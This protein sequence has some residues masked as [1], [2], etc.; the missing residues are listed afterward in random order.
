MPDLKLVLNN[1]DLLRN[2]SFH[3]CVRLNRYNQSH[4][5]SF[6]P[7]DGDFNLCEFTVPSLTPFNI[8]IEIDSF[9][10]MKGTHGEVFIS[11]TANHVV[12]NCVVTFPLPTSV[13]SHQF[14]CSFGQVCVR[15]KTVTWNAGRVNFGKEAVLKGFL[16]LLSVSKERP[17]LSIQFKV[18]QFSASGLKIDSLHIDNVKYKAFKGMRSITQSGRYDIRP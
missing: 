5:L 11:V 15:E 14:S 12:E 8:P 4:E 3:P 16:S 6:I 10:K 1:S 17:V 9:M 7:P 18:A 13:G 2:C